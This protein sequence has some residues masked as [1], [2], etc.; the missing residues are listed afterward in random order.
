MIAN[1]LNLAAAAAAAAAVDDE[2]LVTLIS[3]VSGLTAIFATMLLVLGYASLL[4]AGDEL[5]VT[6]AG[7]SLGRN[8]AGVGRRPVTRRVCFGAE[9]DQVW[10][11]L[12]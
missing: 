7:L 11:L 10:G 3:N 9:L 2:R 4:A 5:L 8:G 6:A 1:A 12:G